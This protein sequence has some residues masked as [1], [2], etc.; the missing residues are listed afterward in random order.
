MSVAAPHRRRAAAALLAALVTLP[1]AWAAA[2]DQ[3]TEDG[4]TVE[5]LQAET[6][7]IV[8]AGVVRD[9]MNAIFARGNEHWDELGEVNTLTQMLGGQPTQLEYLGCLKGR[10]ERDTV[11]VTGWEPA[12][13][14]KRLQFAVT[15]SCEEVASRVGT[16]H[17]HPYRAAFDGK[18]LKER[19]LSRDDLATFGTGF[20]PIVFAVWDIDSLDAAARARNGSV[21]HP[22]GV[23]VR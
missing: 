9:S 23:V 1:P 22:A 14:M 3:P 11:F 7:P 12:R 16:F 6:R 19:S 18:A 10:V 8:V 4:P 17:T 15:G 5:R 2:G 13:N 21:R 20:D